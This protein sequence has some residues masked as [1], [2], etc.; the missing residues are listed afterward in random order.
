MT[1]DPR[2]RYEIRAATRADKDEILE[3]ARFLDSVNLPNDEPTIAEILEH[4]E[5][6]FTGEIGDPRRRNYVF[7]LRDLEQKRAVGTS[8]VI[9]QLGRKDAPYIYFDVHVEERY[10]ATLDKHFAHQV[11]SIGYSYN[12]P[13][14]I[15]GL[16]V[17]PAVRRS[18][19]RLGMLIS[20]VRFLWIA[21]HRDD[22][23]DR[24]LAELLPPLEPDGT[25]HLWESVGRHFTGLTYREADRLSKRNKEFIRGLFPDGDIYASLLRPEAQDVIGKVGPQTRGVEKLLRRIGFRYWNRVDPFDGGPHFIAQTD[26]ILLVQRT[27]GARVLRSTTDPLPGAKALI[28]REHDAAPHFHAV[29]SHFQLAAEGTGQVVLPEETC[30]H[31]GLVPGDEI[32]LLPLD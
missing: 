31:L 5:Q 10:S 3:L 26:E 24:V 2:V 4:S 22:F 11:L 28:A 27:R 20:Y 29:P 8:M 1:T 9:A 6:S 12:G 14:E 23:Q 19:E 16:V 15:G 17:H 13:T 30:L 21:Q 18:P 25:S 7:V 32:A